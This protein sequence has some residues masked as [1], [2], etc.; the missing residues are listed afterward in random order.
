MPHCINGKNPYEYYSCE[1]CDHDCCCRCKIPNCNQCKESTLYYNEKFI[2]MRIFCAVSDEPYVVKNN[3]KYE[4]HYPHIKDMPKCAYLRPMYKKKYICFKCKHMETKYNTL[5]AK[6][7]EEQDLF[8]KPQCKCSKC[9][10]FMTLV[11]ERYRIP[12]KNKT[13]QWEQLEKD[14]KSGK[15]NYNIRTLEDYNKYI[16]R[17]YTIPNPN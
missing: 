9:H 3:G 11:D 8:D 12:K 2:D 10:M 1:N 17:N 13:K 4:T 7:Y 5:V 14:I 16:G 6:T 15:Y